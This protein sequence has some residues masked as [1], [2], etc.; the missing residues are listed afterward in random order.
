MVLKYYA[1]TKDTPLSD[2]LRQ[3]SINTDNQLIVLYD[4]S[5]KDCLDTGRITRAYTIFYQ[6]GP[7]EHGTHVP[8]PFSQSGAE[9]EYN[10][11][12]TTVMALAHFRM[13]IYE[14]LNKDK[15]IVPET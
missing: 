15:N 5:W 8:G 11:T 4:S 13:L 6:G 1:E 9:S 2:L 3:A 7:I 10:A 14:F 12:C